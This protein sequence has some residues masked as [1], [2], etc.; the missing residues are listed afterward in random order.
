[1]ADAMR[2]S[3]A[4]S[5]MCVAWTRRVSMRFPALSTHARPRPDVTMNE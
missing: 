4:R 1:M 2:L 5:M 3:R